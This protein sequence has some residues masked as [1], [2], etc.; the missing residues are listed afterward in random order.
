M[1]MYVNERHA[2]TAKLYSIQDDKLNYTALVY[3]CWMRKSSLCGDAAVHS[4]VVMAGGDDGSFDNTRFTRASWI[5]PWALH[6]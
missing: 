2:T 4:V 3:H 1:W 6:R 5:G